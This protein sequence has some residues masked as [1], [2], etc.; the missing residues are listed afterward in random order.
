MSIFKEWAKSGHSY[1]DRITHL[2]NGG[3][4]NGNV[5]L[6]QNTVTGDKGGSTLVGGPDMDWFWGQTNEVLDL[7]SGEVLN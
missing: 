3:G 5:V 6:N 1:A 2:R 4:W 7:E